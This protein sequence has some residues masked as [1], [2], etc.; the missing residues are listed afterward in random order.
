MT[1]TPDSRTPAPERTPYMTIDTAAPPLPRYRHEDPGSMQLRDVLRVI[2]RSWLIIVA[3]VVAGLLAGWL[4]TVFMP[5]RYETETKVLVDPVISVAVDG[6][7]PANSVSQ[8]SALVADRVETYAALAQT[9]AV[10]DP[11][12]D[13][14][15][16]DVASTD[17]VDN[18]TAEVLPRT[19]II[20]ITVEA[21]TP[22]NAAELANAIAAS[23]ITQIEG[24][25]AAASPVN[26][27]GTV[28]EAPE[29][30]DE[31][32]S[33]LLLLNLLVGLAVGLLV[34]FL[35]I[36]F[37]QALSAGTRGR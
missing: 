10:L 18:V 29:I 11:A 20:N 33:P 16:A 13:A 32:A 24:E 14:I 22:T 1:S 7:T 31:L 25:D 21:S 37:R 19:S 4:V 2:R 27:T 5:E 35:V 30:P 23:L 12:I 28:V 3:A 8:A 15:G 17:L 26:V 9:P 36:V 6:T 34:A